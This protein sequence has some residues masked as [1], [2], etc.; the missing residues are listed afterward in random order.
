MYAPG[1]AG[2]IDT[3][4]NSSPVNV[5]KFFSMRYDDFLGNIH[6]NID[7]YFIHLK[8]LLCY[9]LTVF[10]FQIFQIYLLE[11][12][13]STEWYDSKKFDN[14]SHMRLWF[15]KKWSEELVSVP[16]P[17]CEF[18]ERLLAANEESI[19]TRWRV[20]CWHLDLEFPSLQKCKT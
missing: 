6:G 10:M 1:D 2:F 15:C 8:Q 9:E 14:R 4:N 3:C 19:P 17:P 18:I 12:H 13:L 11:P 20:Y 7:I 5:F 16:F